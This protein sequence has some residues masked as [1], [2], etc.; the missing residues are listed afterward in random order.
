MKLRTYF[1][2]FLFLFGMAPLV[3]AVVINLPFVMHKLE[4]F[5]HKAHVQN[6]RSDFRDLDHHITSHQE[7]ARIL[8][9]LMESDVV[10]PG[11]EGQGVAWAISR[12]TEWVWLILRDKQ[13]IFQVIYLDVNGTPR[14]WLERDP[15]N[16][17][18]RATAD[19]P[20]VPPLE[21]REEAMS[22]ESGAVLVSPVMLNLRTSLDDSRRLMTMHLFSPV[23]QTDA[24]G[25]APGGM[26]VLNMDVGNMARSYKNTLW[27]N[28][29]GSY[30]TNA[31]PKSGTS[32]AFRDFPGL[33]KIFSESKLALWKGSDSQMIW[34]PLFKTDKSGKVWVGREVGP[35]P[36]AAFR[37]A[38]T[39]RVLSIIFVLI[40]IVF[41]VARW[42]A[43]RISGFG[44]ELT[45][46][47]GRLLK[48]EDSVAFDWG[49]PQELHQLGHDL[50]H[51]AKLYAGNVQELRQHASK[52]EE[53]NRYKSEFLANVSHELRTPL[54]SIL[55][56]SKLLSDSESDLT[57]KQA[58]KARVIHEAGVD[59]RSL[60]DN[61]LDLSRIEAQEMK[62]NLRQ[63]EIPKLIN[64]VIGLMQPQFDA[65][66]LGLSFEQ[67]GD[68]PEIMISDREKLGQILKNFLSNALKFTKN[69]GVIIRLHRNDKDDA[70]VRPVAIS[71]ID[72]G[73]GIPVHKL[74][75]VFGA[76]QQVDGSTSR[77]YGG[78]GLGLSISK[79]LAELLGGRIVLWSKESD[80]SVFTVLLPRELDRAGSMVE[81]I[82]QPPQDGGLGN[83]GLV[84]S[85][86]GPIFEPCCI[87]IMDSDIQNLL[88]LTP[89][90][91]RWGLQVMAAGD[92]EEAIDTLN[93]E[94][95]CGL[96]LM[97]TEML[98]V[99]GYGTINRIRGMN[100]QQELP[101][102]AMMSGQSE[103]KHHSA[104]DSGV[105]DFIAKPIQAAEL[106]QILIRYLKT[107]L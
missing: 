18:W 73:I 50:N 38:L 86:G 87:L 46:G 55:L 84:D 54:N 45:D 105:N 101:V 96:V 106:Q 85:A 20:D 37:N 70:T 41:L 82:E 107:T 26:L 102:I 42:Y 25:I 35:S 71:V 68:A 89:L 36:V 99:Q 75:V 77:K 16:M 49:G 95:A 83:Q 14:F 88:M 12:Y 81:Y 90:L 1:F 9:R 32:S 67:E 52:L 104:E 5:Y 34:V 7:V 58:E 60:I 94:G 100:Q 98:G 93:D 48:N 72:S 44:N 27:V 40:I 30:I 47:I 91:E 92:A 61:I 11:W 2:L 24:S 78:T 69:G 80:G 6:L 10:P 103:E 43:K 21:L 56:L 59:L 63:F 17:L 29:S 53:S 74:S 66:G 22:M 3:T 64:E 76:F 33:K 97:D 31:R 79:N 19:T 39:L 8:A 51:L 57:S 65:K 15:E 62:F 4:L 23:V 28:S 13:D